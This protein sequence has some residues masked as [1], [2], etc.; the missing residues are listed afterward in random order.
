MIK[1]NNNL[2]EENRNS[3][4]YTE[5]E[6]RYHNNKIEVLIQKL[7]IV[8]AICLVV[9]TT[10]NS[11]VFLATMFGR[12]YDKVE[13]EQVTSDWLV[14]IYTCHPSQLVEVYDEYQKYMN[15]TDKYKFNPEV[16]DNLIQ[17]HLNYTSLITEVEILHTYQQG[18]KYLVM[19]NIL[20]PAT[21]TATEI[22][23][24]RLAEFHSDLGL[25]TEW[26]EWVVVDSIVTRE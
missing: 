12:K 11:I 4:L 22:N 6:Y 2:Q 10:L 1:L 9:M 5:E 3:N 25:L 8:C 21:G 14:A 7:K 15:T 17:R 16:L 18:N 13:L 24:L 23:E 26:N 19:Y 20:V